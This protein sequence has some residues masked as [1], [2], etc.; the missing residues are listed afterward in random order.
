M[1]KS[2]LKT[3]ISYN[4]DTNSKTEIKFDSNICVENKL[5]NNNFLYSCDVRKDFFY[6]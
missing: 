4:E 3:N 1:S 2:I 6:L 5:A